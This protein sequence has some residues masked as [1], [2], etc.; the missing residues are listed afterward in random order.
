MPRGLLPLLRQPQVTNMC[1]WVLLLLYSSVCQRTALA[2]DCLPYYGHFL[3]SKDTTVYCYEGEWWTIAA[4]AA[5]SIALFCIGL[6]LALLLGVRAWRRGTTRQQ[7]RI[8]LLVHS[9]VPEAWYL[10]LIHI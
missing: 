8:G 10:S 4:I 5:V 2:F 7:A 3:L 9:Y 1:F 6:P